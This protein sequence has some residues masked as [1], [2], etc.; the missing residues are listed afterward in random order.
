MKVQLSLSVLALA[1]TSSHAAPSSTKVIGSNSRRYSNP[2]IYSDAIP[3]PYPGSS[4]AYN[5][6]TEPGYSTENQAGFLNMGEEFQ[7]QGP[8][9]SSWDPQQNA[10]NG[11][12]YNNPPSTQDQGSTGGLGG[13]PMSY[14][15]SS[16]PN[17]AKNNGPNYESVNNYQQYAPYSTSNQPGSGY[18]PF[19]SQG[20][21]DEKTLEEDDNTASEAGFN[22]PISNLADNPFY[23]LFSSEQSDT[24]PIDLGSFKNFGPDDQTPYSISAIPPPFQPPQLTSQSFASKDN[25]DEKTLEEDSDNTLDESS[26]PSFDSTGYHH[27]Q[28]SDGQWKITKTNDPAD[29]T[30]YSGFVSGSSSRPLPS[31][32]QLGPKNQIDGSPEEVKLTYGAEENYHLLATD[33]EFEPPTGSYS[34]DRKHLVGRYTSQLASSAD[35][36]YKSEDANK[37]LDTRGSMEFPKK[38]EIASPSGFLKSTSLDNSY[39]DFADNEPH[40]QSVSKNEETKDEEPIASENNRPFYQRWLGSKAHP[41]DEE[42]QMVPNPEPTPESQVPFWKR[43]FGGAK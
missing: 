6:Y 7:K 43:I 30:P 15:R 37:A 31:L 34:G 11:Y 42:N 40:S 18:P 1:A 8:I 39:T 9:G 29:L 3:P 27:P 10:E 20:N 17:Y 35:M 24:G 21:F 5:S 16:Q 26:S 25:Y 28:H 22:P 33:A 36:N 2:S 13:I 32:D 4:D 14:D 12:G 41:H 38:S 19:T 23:K